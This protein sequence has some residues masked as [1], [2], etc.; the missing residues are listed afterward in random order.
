MVFSC[1]SATR[2]AAD[3]SDEGT[4]I[5]PKQRSLVI[6]Y[7]LYIVRDPESKFQEPRL[8]TIHL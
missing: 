1:S 7:D 6:S 3:L 4:P 8:Y 5:S 2:A